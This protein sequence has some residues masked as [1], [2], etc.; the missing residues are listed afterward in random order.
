M[1]WLALHLPWLPLEVFHVDPAAASPAAPAARCVVDERRVCV[2]DEAALAAGITPGIAAV[3]AQAL[4]PGVVLLPREP[5]REA[6]LLELLALACSG[7]TPQ[8]VVLPDGLLLEVAGSLRL[9]GGLR[10]LIGRLRESLAASRV[11]ARIG[12]APT[13]GAARLFAR[14]PGPDRRPGRVGQPAH[15]RALLDTLALPAV[16]AVLQTDPLLAGLLHGI[17]CRC[18]GDVRALPRA[19]FQRRGGGALLQALDRVY[20][21]APDP[22]TWFAPPLRFS[23]ELELPQRAD[24]AAMVGFAAQRLLQALG[25]WLARQWL[26][27]A[28]FSLWLQHETRGRHGRAPTRLRVELGA[29]SRDPAQLGL[30]LRERL[31]RCTLPA[32]VYGL[33]LALDDAV[34]LAGHETGLPF[35]LQRDGRRWDDPAHDA[36]A[37]RALLDRLSSR[38]GASQVRRLQLRADH[39]PERAMQA[40]AAGAAA[41]A[42]A[43]AARP[44]SSGKKRAAASSMGSG[45]GPASIEAQQPAH[46]PPLVAGPTLRAD[47]AMSRGGTPART[48][49]PGKKP[50]TASSRPG[51]DGPASVEAPSALPIDGVPAAMAAPTPPAGAQRWPGDAPARAG[52][53]CGPAAS[54]TPVAQG[55]A[56]MAPQVAEPGDGAPRVQP[57][58]PSRPAWLLPD[59]LRLAE[60]GGQPVHGGPLKLRSRAERIEAGWVDGALVCRDYYVAEGRDRRLRWVFRERLGGRGEGGWFLHGLFG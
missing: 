5:A 48:V 40:V 4:L 58:A 31:A 60:Q 26:A 42:P 29:A 3:S 7:Y 47:A 51:A 59:P 54:A 34:A 30:L 1:L 19:A 17:G 22:Q 10:A 20:G 23:A 14:V 36:A 57:A 55:A 32:P 15:S 12:W 49:M 28:G 46:R 52:A 27:A 41:A 56:A 43:A 2:A 16:L 38:L 9:F 13:P 53:A 24:D 18:L 35:G 21:D 37:W 50:G 6:A 25:G 11:R 8:L 39:R 33:T 45:L 44:D